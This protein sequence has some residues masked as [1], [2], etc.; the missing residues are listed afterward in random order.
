MTAKCK[1]LRE[2]NSIK[3]YLIEPLARSPGNLSEVSDIVVQRI[4]G[5]S[6]KS[7]FVWSRRLPECGFVETDVS[8][9]WLWSRYLVLINRRRGDPNRLGFAGHALLSAIS[10]TNEMSP[11]SRWPSRVE[12]FAALCATWGRADLASSDMVSLET[13]K[14]VWQARLDPRRKL[15]SCPNGANPNLPGLRSDAEV[16]GIV[17]GLLDREV[18]RSIA[19]HGGQASIIEVR[20]G[21]LFIAM[22]GGC[23]ECAASRRRSSILWTRPITRQGRS[24]SIRGQGSISSQ[25]IL[26]APPPQNP[27]ARMLRYLIAR[28]A[29]GLDR[30][31][32]ET[33]WLR[34]S[35]SRCPRASADNAI[36]WPGA[37][38]P[39]CA[40]PPRAS[41]QPVSRLRRE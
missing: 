19:S 41:P 22:S 10:G 4:D 16:R 21:K 37:V 18:N 35:R 3:G 38:A 36:A 6:N 1:P 25:P 15:P 33:R 9:K 14:R 12:K 28:A 24:R 20:D 13:S 39:R 23:Q 30:A 34:S 31:A 26:R 29:A 8:G 40:L 5:E 17:Q 2:L 27:P 7:G 32:V 11:E